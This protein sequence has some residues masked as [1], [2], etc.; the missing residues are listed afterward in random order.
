MST[1]IGLLRHG[2]TDW[3][4][5]MRLQ[6]VSDIPLND[7]GREQANTAAEVLSSSTWEMIVSSPLSRALETANIVASKLGFENVDI[8]PE[9]IERSFGVA[10]GLSYDDW[11]TRYQDGQ[12]VDQAETIAQLDVRANALLELLALKFEGQR[13]LT[14]S[15]GALIRRLIHIISN[16]EFP[17]EGE[18]FGN[19]SMTTIEHD[20]D[21]WKIL[22]YD[23]KPLS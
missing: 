3:N 1:I 5:D 23:P 7:Y 12:N 2:Q 9:L 8:L 18:R 13:V 20:G 16:G 4:V 19:A 10:E 22:N 11:K 14:V 17:R 21:D 15:H 6:G